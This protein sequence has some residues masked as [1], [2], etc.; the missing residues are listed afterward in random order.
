MVRH[1]ESESKPAVQDG[2]HRQRRLREGDGV[3]RLDGH[4]G[5]AHLDSGSRRTHDH[6]CGECIE[7]VGDLRNPYRGQTGFFRPPGV[8]AQ[9]L[10]LGPVPAPLGP[11]HRAYAHLPSP[12]SEPRTRTTRSCLGLCS[13]RSDPPQARDG[14]S[15]RRSG[16][17]SSRTWNPWDGCPSQPTG[18]R[19]RDPVRC[20]R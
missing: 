6:R 15:S 10:H 17:S 19:P 18:C 13:R 2:L 4:H 5:G 12:N 9:P 8:V 20:S 7:V 1:A 3:A 16:S 14:M 11:D